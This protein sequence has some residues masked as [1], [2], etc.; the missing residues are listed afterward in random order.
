[1]VQKVMQL[2]DESKSGSIDKRE[3]KKALI[4]AAN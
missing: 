1:M 4:E 3:L 2:L